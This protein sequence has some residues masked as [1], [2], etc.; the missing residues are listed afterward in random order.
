MRIKAI[1]EGKEAIG[2]WNGKFYKSRKNPERNVRVYIDGVEYDIPKEE[3]KYEEVLSQKQLKYA[4]DL[5]L[6][7]LEK[8]EEIFGEKKIKKEY[9]E[10]I[11]KHFEGKE[12][13]YFLRNQIY[14]PAI[15][16]SISVRPD[17]VY[18]VITGKILDRFQVV[19]AKKEIPEEVL[20]EVLLAVFTY[21]VK[22]LLFPSHKTEVLYIYEDEEGYYVRFFEQD[23]FL[24]FKKNKEVISCYKHSVIEGDY[25]IKLIEKE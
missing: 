12:A 23:Y 22:T 4:W 25:I 15:L 21:S 18:A 13:A 6:R 19:E 2:Y 10:T 1:I 11:R 3:F 17:I 7:F 20:R 9:E 8:L 5:K 14:L 24:K 16:S